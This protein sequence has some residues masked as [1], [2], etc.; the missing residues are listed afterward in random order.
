MYCDWKFDGFLFKCVCCFN[1]DVTFYNFFNTERRITAT[2]ERT[3]V[4]RNSERAYR[5]GTWTCRIQ[6]R[7][8]ICTIGWQEVRFGQYFRRYRE[9]MSLHFRM[10][11]LCYCYVIVYAYY[12]HIMIL[13]RS[14]VTWFYDSHSLLYFSKEVV[15]WYQYFYMFISCSDA[16]IRWSHPTF[17]APNFSIYSTIFF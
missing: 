9:F 4:V 11:I 10:V 8:T 14:N 17:L 2:P 1:A 3:K 16:V 15:L 13:Q 7:L 5:K 6:R 12:T